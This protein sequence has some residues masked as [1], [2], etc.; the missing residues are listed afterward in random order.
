MKIEKYELNIPNIN[1][2]KN[3]TKRIKPIDLKILKTLS[4][5]SS[6]PFNIISVIR[7]I[8]YTN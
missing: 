4:F 5:I 8:I 2:E 3:K 6:L 1:E 7:K